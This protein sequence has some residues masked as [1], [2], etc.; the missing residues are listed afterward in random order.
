MIEHA[1]VFEHLDEDSCYQL[2]A[3]PQLRAGVTQSEV[4]IKLAQYLAES[5]QPGKA[6][7]LMEHDAGDDPDALGR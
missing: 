1:G 3:Y 2:A 5:G 6:I 4:R 7:A